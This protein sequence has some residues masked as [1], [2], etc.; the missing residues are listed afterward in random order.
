M[1]SRVTI[2]PLMMPAT[3]DAA[4]TISASSTQF[5]SVF[6]RPHAMNTPPKAATEPAD[7]SLPP[8]M[9]R[10]VMPMAVSPIRVEETRMLMKFPYVK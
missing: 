7:R 4:R 8:V 5:M 1:F 6:F 10:K 9:I 2:R 3:E